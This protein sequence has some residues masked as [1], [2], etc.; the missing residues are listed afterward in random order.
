M[1]QPQPLSTDFEVEDRP[2]DRSRRLLAIHDLHTAWTDRQ[3]AIGTP[4]N[5]GDHPEG[6][7]YNQHSPALD[8][9]GQ[10][11]DDFVAAANQI[12][13]AKRVP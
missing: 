3:M 13:H 4:F 5:P 8:A 1:N 12:L 7:D 11:Q 9:P 2:A 10:E 6:S